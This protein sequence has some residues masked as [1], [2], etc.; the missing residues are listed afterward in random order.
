MR[1]FLFLILAFALIPVRFLAQEDAGSAMSVDERLLLAADAGDT[2]QA[3]KMIMAGAD[4]DA[5]T[6]EGATGLM[7]AVQNG[8]LPMVR[9]LLL[10][11]ADPD[12]KPA[13]GRTALITAVRSGWVD[14]VEYLIRNG[15]GVNLPDNEKMTPLMHAIAVDSF[16]LADMLLYYDADHTLARKDGIDPLMLAAHL[17]RGR[18]AEEL[19]DRG[20]DFNRTDNSGRTA[21]H[22]AT[23]SGCGEVMQQLIAAGAPLE[24]KTTSG[25]SPLSAAVASNLYVP[26]RLL[27]SSGADVNSRISNG[28]NPLSMARE[29]GYDSLA[30]MLRNNQAR[31][32]RLPW[33]SL[34]SAGILTRFSGDDFYTGMDVGIVDRKYNLSVRAGYSFRPKAIRVLEPVQG[35]N[36]YQYWERRSVYT[37]SLSKAF[38][39]NTSRNGYRIGLDVGLSGVMS[40]GNYRG[41]SLKPGLS[42]MMSPGIGVVVQSAKLRTYLNYTYMDLS[43][44]EMSRSWC[45]AGIELMISRKKGAMKFKPVNGL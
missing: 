24:K 8:N 38:M 43:L 13:N 28:L 35:G 1:H 16:Y 41:S 27:I 39:L 29:A 40:Y 25:Y 44:P 33:F 34:Y 45:T 37:L 14:I 4:V 17:C 30:V 31:P 26:A 11:G 15:A 21:L 9:L 18:I 6:W 19:I 42:Y 7:F 5:S 10:S 20:A 2:L 32:I 22:F 3:K 12:K 23:L 36:F